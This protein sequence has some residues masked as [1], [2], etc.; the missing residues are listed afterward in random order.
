M[1]LPNG[2]GSVYKLSGK[3]RCP[4]IARVTTGWAVDMD[5]KQR[6]QQYATIGYFKT[7]Q[8]ALLALAAYRE[9]PYDLHASS[10]TFEQAYDKW[11]AD[12]FLTLSNRSSVRT[13]TCAW[14]YCEPLY[15]MRIRDIRVSHLEGTIKAADTGNSTKQ[16]MKS[17]FNMLYRW[18]MKNEIVDKDYAQLCDGVKR[19]KAQIVRIP[20]SVA[21]V[22]TLYD[23]TALPFVP[24]ILIG[25]YS[26]WR[27]QELAVLKVVDIDLEHW[28]YT[29]GLKSDAGRNRM[30][31][32][33]SRVRD[34]V[35]A[36]YDKAVALGADTLFTDETSQTG[37][38]LTYDK[39]RARFNKVMRK[40]KM[41]HKPHD[42]R[43]TFITNAKE[44]GVDE[45]ML[46]MIVGH[47]IEDI[48][49]R[50]YTHRTMQQLAAEIEKIK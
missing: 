49:E 40:L 36:E 43:H 46:K 12:Y 18:A 13:I 42:T 47:E 22:Q 5:T 45:Y 17:I 8:D 3:R 19:E 37:I 14:K 30:V 28:V 10:M 29:G 24:M 44:A 23:N 50:V 11:S 26:G 15:N 31:P 33:H 34:L 41:D 6:K 32:M 2:Y 7:K 9:N 25:I 27:P 4:Y 38:S 20:F 21:E 1:K 39:Y 48:T 16:R 35:Q